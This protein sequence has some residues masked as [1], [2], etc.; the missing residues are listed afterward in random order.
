MDDSEIKTDWRVR[1]SV[2]WTRVVHLIASGVPG[3]A[4]EGRVRDA[5]RRLVALDFLLADL[6]FIA[7]T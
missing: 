5:K 3:A 2:I 7:V 1:F 6:A 4:R